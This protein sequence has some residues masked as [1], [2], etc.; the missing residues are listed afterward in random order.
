MQVSGPN[1]E[2]EGGKKGGGG[3]DDVDGDGEKDGDDDDAVESN[4]P[5]TGK[6]EL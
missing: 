3:G 1:N 6:H 4:F 2:A 5:R